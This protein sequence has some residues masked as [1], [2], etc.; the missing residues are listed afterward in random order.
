M[1]IDVKVQMQTSSPNANSIL[2]SIAR[3][4][5]WFENHHESNHDRKWYQDSA[6]SVLLAC[7][8][9]SKLPA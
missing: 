7:K 3:K 5:S 8:R 1:M 4:R 6:P 2:M 9:N